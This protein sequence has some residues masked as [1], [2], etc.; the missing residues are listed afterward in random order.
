VV[1]SKIQSAS[2]VTNSG[3]ILKGNMGKPEILTFGEYIKMLPAELVFERIVKKTSISRRIISDGMTKEISETFASEKNLTRIFNELSEKSRL[4]CSQIYLFDSPVYPVKAQDISILL[5]KNTT[6]PEKNI[7]DIDNTDMELVD[8]F[9]VCVCRG[10]DGKTAYSGFKEFEPVLR[11]AFCLTI[12]KSAEVSKP[13]T[14]Q[15][16][17]PYTCLKDIA[18]LISLAAHKK[19]SKT[20]T[21]SWAKS[22][23][24][25]ISKLL[26]GSQHA[27]NNGN[28]FINPV[29]LSFYYS[30][31]KH[32]LIPE[33]ET[34]SVSHEIVTDWLSQPEDKR[35][36]E[37]AETAFSIF[38]L[39]R[40]SMLESIFSS[41]DGIWL[42]TAGFDVCIQSEIK[43][44]V[45][46]LAYCGILDF[47]KSG[48]DL[49]FTA[50]KK[51]APAEGKQPVGK[52]CDSVILQPDMSAILPQEASSET[53]YWFSLIGTLDSLD[54][55]YK[56]QITKETVCN[57]LSSGV[58]GE[59]LIRKL[60]SWNAP[61][62]VIENV[63]EW[64][65]EFLRLFI[66]NDSI[67]ASSTEKVTRQIL[68]YHP[69]KEYMEQVDAHSFFRIYRG[70][71]KK[72]AEI[73]ES[74]GFD[75]RTTWHEDNKKN[76]NT[77]YESPDYYSPVEFSP[78]V[79]FKT[80]EKSPEINV[81][82]GK[83]SSQLKALDISDIIH[84]IDYALLMGNRLKIEYSGNLGIRKGTYCIRPLLLKKGPAPSLEAESGK[85]KD[86]KNFLIA[87]INKIG[88]I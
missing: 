13:K 28:S 58:S 56:G 65:R 80:E 74:M 72:A 30:Q 21:S 43:T 32:L 14:V 46:I 53:L 52:I 24:L 54:K 7:L 86:I 50:I 62:S 79:D 22:S 59:I 69:L 8:S 49:I 51:S 23:S 15:F 57:S 36:L 61:G 88:V 63:R 27:F 68:S 41:N 31:D 3:T 67:I 11:T 77:P 35:C 42:S 37:I 47:Y 9:L 45:R 5:Q 26:Y 39:W 6:N 40:K 16:I 20:R 66:M 71:E 1:H 60:S 38:P 84:V 76:L 2:Q 82:Q 81:K 70:K 78:V 85:K 33:E 12:K 87:S 75:L 83:Y 19:L 44:V 48:N 73:L 25:Y 64:I 29:N 17:P 18:V 34:F 4:R 10:P 55:V